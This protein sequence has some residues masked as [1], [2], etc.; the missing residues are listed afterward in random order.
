MS[1]NSEFEVRKEKLKNM[2]KKEKVAYAEK[3]DRDIELSEAKNLEDGKNVSVCG[4]IISY[5]DFGKFAFIKLYDINGT[6]QISISK[7][8][9]GEKYNEI[10]KC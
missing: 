10:K 4:R 6:L 9:L 3:F 2:Q 1:L 7:N 5:R 8:E